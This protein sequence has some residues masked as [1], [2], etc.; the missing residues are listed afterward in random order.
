MRFLFTTLAGSGHFH[1]LLPPAEALQS[2]GHDVCFATA[3][4][5]HGEIAAGGFEVFRRF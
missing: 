3:P 2:K 1:P 5:F 4:S